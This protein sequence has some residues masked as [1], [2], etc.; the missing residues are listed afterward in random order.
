[1]KLRTWII[2]GALA[3]LAAG[4]YIFG[5]DRRGDKEETT[6]KFELPLG[7]SFAIDN[8]YTVWEVMPVWRRNTFLGDYMTTTPVQIRSVAQPT[9]QDV[10]KIVRLPGGILGKW[11]CVAFLYV[12]QIKPVKEEPKD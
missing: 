1:M 8:S 11:E 2:L 5:Y 7:A 10:T 4:F 12:K 9:P 6:P 3:T